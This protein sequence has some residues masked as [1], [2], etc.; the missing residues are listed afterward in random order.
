LLTVILTWT[1]PQR[2]STES[3]VTVFEPAD[4]AE[5]EDDDEDGVDSDDPDPDPD[6]G[7]D[8]DPDDSPL[9]EPPVS[10]PAAP[11]AAGRPASVEWDL[12]DSRNTRP[13][14]VLRMASTARRM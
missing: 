8:D 11:I 10:V 1:G 14:T 2:V 7:P 13:V 12:K 3:P 6:P 4:L 5:D 9:L